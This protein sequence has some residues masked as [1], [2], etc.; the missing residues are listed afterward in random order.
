MNETFL[1]RAIELARESVE[2]GGGPFGAVVVRDGVIVGEGTNRVVPGRDP[3]A[4]AEILALR[5]AATAL[6]THEL[7]GCELYASSEPCP[8]CA[9]AAHWARIDALVFATDRADAA[10][11]GFDDSLLFEQLAADPADRHVVGHQSLR[12]EGQAIFDLWLARPDRVQ[13]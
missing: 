13:Y 5:A 8:M 10:A 2:A 12:A 4:H 1:R 7:S 9:A 11:A 3:T 6:S